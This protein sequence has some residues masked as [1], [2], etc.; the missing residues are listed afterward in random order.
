M[1]IDA[2]REKHRP[3]LEG[4]GDS[5]RQ[6][7]VC[8]HE[9]CDINTLLGFL[10]VREEQLAEVSRIATLAVNQLTARDEMD[11]NLSTLLT[12]KL[13]NDLDLVIAAQAAN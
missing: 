6:V 3:I 12:T 5:V 11:L 10:S 2:L 1:S 9:P 7:C 13:H 8:G 4:V